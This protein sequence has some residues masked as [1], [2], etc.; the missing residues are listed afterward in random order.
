MK[1]VGFKPVA[2]PDARVLILGTLPSAESLR[3]CEY[4]A[5][6]ANNFW[7]IIGELVGARPEMAYADR[8]RQL[9]KSGVALWDVC[10]SAERSGSLDARILLST[11][12]PNDFQSFLRTHARIQLICFN[13]G[14]AERIFRRKVPPDI[15][16]IP[17]KVLPSTSPAHTRMKYNEKVSRW[18]DDLAEVIS[19]SPQS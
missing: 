1:C 7:R 19:L 12:V 5:N 15:F 16:Q 3:R 14:A 8:L 4:Y 6:P 9:R 2:D 10:L 13:G 18:R 11:V 17:C